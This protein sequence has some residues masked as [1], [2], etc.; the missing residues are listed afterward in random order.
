[1]GVTLG[2]PS[3]SGQPPGFVALPFEAFHPD[4]LPISVTEVQW[5]TDG[6]L[7]WSPATLAP[8]NDSLST[9]PSGSSRTILWN[10]FA[11]RAGG[12]GPVSAQLRLIPS[13]GEPQVSPSFVVDSTSAATG[14]THGSILRTAEDG[15]TREFQ[16][17][18]DPNLDL[19]D[20][21]RRIALDPKRK[22]MYVFGVTK[23][24]SLASR[25]RLERRRLDNGSL[26]GG[27]AWGE[28]FIDFPSIGGAGKDEATAIA[29]DPTY[30]YL[31]GIVRVS[32]ETPQHRW[33]VKRLDAQT[34]AE[35]PGFPTILTANPD[36]YRDTK[37][38]LALNSESL[39]LVGTE[40]N[41]DWQ[42]RTRFERRA[43][44][45]GSSEKVETWTPESGTCRVRG[46]V[47]DDA[48]MY[49]ASSVETFVD[50]EWQH[51][52]LLQ[53]WTLDGAIYANY[54]APAQITEGDDEPTSIARHSDSLYV[55]VRKNAPEIGVTLAVYRLLAADAGFLG[56][57]EFPE[58]I[59]WCE[60]SIVLDGDYFYVAL[61]RYLGPGPSSPGEENFDYEWVI[62]QRLAQSDLEADSD[63]PFRNHDNPLGVVSF[64]YGPGDDRPED[65]A[66][67]GGIIYAVGRDKGPDGMKGQ[68]R[69]Q[70]LYR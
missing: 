18:S 56:V 34:G 21:A 41:N 10:S 48:A 23:E 8:W 6:G 32:A 57:A 49:V 51:D 16:A 1:L 19:Q 40:M 30:I 15:Q 50:G 43:L 24:G 52:T 9:I 54:F 27:D 39:F 35:T 70:A 7:W 31:G 67:A 29:L 37:V 69:I 13:L 26:L 17:S 45:D 2:A 65:I 63:F 59:R 20:E 62:W 33:A 55:T 53:R 42:P 12:F 11:D 46:M 38:F 4:G 5:S 66:V 61:K 44:S 28:G 3:L 60:P 36:D 47:I 64:D 25:W 14:L 68:W 22:C 58:P